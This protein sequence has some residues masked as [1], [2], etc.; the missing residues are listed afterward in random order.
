MATT[1]TQKRDFSAERAQ[2][3]TKLFKAFDADSSGDLDLEEFTLLC[4]VAA[5][6]MDPAAIRDSLTLAGARDRVSLTQFH[7]WCHEMFV[8]FSEDEYDAAIEMMLEVRPK[9]RL[10][11]V[12]SY[13]PKGRLRALSEAQRDYIERQKGLVAGIQNLVEQEAAQTRLQAIEVSVSCLASLF[14]AKP[15][16][17]WC[18]TA[19]VG[20]HPSASGSRDWLTS[21][22]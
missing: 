5:P 19:C 10:K 11:N 22:P 2:K 13:H 4:K 12:A 7:R 1:G 21:R 14:L 8:D 17:F 15:L 9:A 6:E 16:V 3:A 18:R 20:D